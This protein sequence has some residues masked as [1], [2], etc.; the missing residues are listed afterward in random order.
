[1]LRTAAR[2][3]LVAFLISA[4]AH[5]ALAERRV[6]LVIGNSN[7]ANAARLPNPVKDAGAIADA[8]SR[9]GFDVTHADNLGVAG[10]RKALQAFEDKANGADWA[11]VYYAGHGMELDGK[12]WLVPVDAALARASDVAD[13]AVPLDRVL[14]RVRPASSLR[15]VILDACRNNPFLTRMIMGRD[16]TRS[17]GRGLAPIQPQRGE[18]VF[19][20]ARDGHVAL[21]GDGPH[22]PFAAAM[23]KVI[24]KPGLELGF[25][26]REVTSDVL[27][28]TAPEA[29]E[30]F[31]YGS[32]PRQKYYFKAPESVEA[33]A[34]A[35][36][37]AQSK[38]HTGGV[39]RTL[40]FDR[41][42][43]GH[44]RSDRADAIA[45]L[46]DGGF[47][48]GGYN[49]SNSSQGAIPWII[50]LDAKGNMLWDKTPLGDAVGGSATSIAVTSDGG[51][52]VSGAGPWIVRFDSHGEVSWKKILGGYDFGRS[53]T[54]VA[55][56]S[57]GFAIAVSDPSK[58]ASVIRLD[59]RGGI[60]WE[61]TFKGKDDSARAIALLPDGGFAV[62][63]SHT[64]SSWVIR[65]DADG[66]ILWD[67]ALSDE[68]GVHA[69]TALPDGGLAVAGWTSPKD[70]VNS[71]FWFAR[72]GVQGD[73][74][75]SKA[76]GPGDIYAGAESIVALP[77]GGLVVAGCT[78]SK[79]D[80]GGHD[81]R[82]IRV[83]GQGDILWDKT[84]GGDYAHSIAVLPDGGIAVAGMTS[85]RGTAGYKFWVF[86]IPPEEQQR[87][88]EGRAER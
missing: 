36:S 74:L 61:K 8:L 14:E 32:L 43:G 77:D 3:V 9:L 26:F 2:F 1:M 7:Y 69:M 80:S 67:K 23:L 37:L 53:A 51:F 20:A 40:A 83:D 10:M 84:F 66:D 59:D 18:V 30:P 72:L 85:T 58:G 63:G 81:A 46:S 22:S 54:I 78:P 29:Q 75:W 16:G 24:E 70:N 52:V 56:P 87:V 4:V 17:L 86:T 25:F 82:V 68:L 19:Y 15:I 31:V 35:P 21:D 50:R 73:M 28:A 79:G 55:L 88:G 6:A 45:A 11:L 71:K 42:F 38:S 64:W 57:G 12:N 39:R 76:F 27:E 13:E 44:P 62:A 48:V 60:L 65:L 47:A 33:S 49:Q 34:P 5:A 41:T